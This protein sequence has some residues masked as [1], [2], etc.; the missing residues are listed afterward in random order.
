MTPELLTAILGAGGLTVIVPKL[1]DG[2]KAWRSGRAL[3]EKD[4]NR[5]LVDRLAVAESRLEAEIIYRRAVEEYA[6]TLRRVLI[7][8]YGVPSERLPPWPVRN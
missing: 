4:K 6:A 1:V 3:E 7:E 5:G 2:L 8:V